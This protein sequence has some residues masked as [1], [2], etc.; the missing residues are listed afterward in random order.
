M[1]KKLHFLLTMMLFCAMLTQAQNVPFHVRFSTSAASC[2]NNGK[3][4]YALMDSQGAVLDSLPD[5]LSQVRI[6][7]RLPNSDT[8]HYSGWY[9]TGGEDTLTINNGTYV[10]G[11]EGLQDNGSGGFVRVDT[12]L[13]MT[14]TTTYQKPEASALVQTAIY[15]TRAGNMPT[16]SCENSGRVQLLVLDGR[17][18]YTVTVCDHSTG[19]TLRTQIFP[20]YQHHGSYAD[21]A[22]Y[23]YYYTFDT[24]GAGTWDFYL[25]DGCGYGLPRI[26]QNVS[27][28][29][30]PKVTKLSV[31]A[32]SGNFA[33]SNVVKVLVKFDKAV[34]PYRT[35]MAQ[36]ARYRIVY[37]GLEAKEWMPLPSSVIENTFMLYDTVYSARKYC[38]IWN[39]KITFE[40]KLEGCEEWQKTLAFQYL[41]PDE[42]YFEKDTADITLAIHENEQPCGTLRDWQRN[43]YS[44]RYYT[45]SV[46]PNKPYL[47]NNIYDVTSDIPIA[48]DYYRYYYTHPLSWVYTDKRTG[49]VIKMDTIGIITDFSYLNAR[50]VE[51][52]YGSLDD[53]TFTIPV[54]RR[55]MDG[56][57]CELYATEDTMTFF[58]SHGRVVP[59][60]TTE[61]TQESQYCC[62][63][64]QS[65]TI[66]QLPSPVSS[67]RISTT[68]RLVRSPDH[69]FYNFVA[70]YDPATERWEITRD[71]VENGAIIEGKYDGRSLSIRDYCL[72][73]GP[74][75][76]EVVTPC[77][78]FLLKLE[79]KFNNYV[80][81]D[82]LEEPTYIVTKDCGNMYIQYTAGRYLRTFFR[83]Y[84]SEDRVDTMES[85]INPIIKVI[86]APHNSY[87]NTSSFSLN[88]PVR[89]SMPGEYIFEFK[90]D[91]INSIPACESMVTYDT[92]EVDI[93][94][95]EFEYALALLCDSSSTMGNAYV[96]G[97]NGTEPYTYILY[98][99]PDRQGEVLGTNNTGVFLNVPMRSNEELSCLISDSCISYFHV[100]FYP[101]TL[102]ELKKVWFDDGLTANST[103]EG[104]TIQVHALSISEVLRYEWS[105]PDGFHAT[106]SDP[107]VHIPRGG[108]SGWYKVVIAYDQCAQELSDSIFLTVQEA[109]HLT[110]T[111]DATVCPGD[112]VEVL[113]VPTTPLD[114]DKVRFEVAF[115]NGSGISSRSYTATPG[116]TVRD[117]FS[118]LSDAKIY[119]VLVDDGRCAYMHADTADTAY[120]HIRT[121]VLPACTVLTTY[122]TVCHG[123]DAQLSA[124]AT[125]SEPY[126]LKWYSDYALTQLLKTDTMINDETWSYYDTAA[127]T[128]R[129]ILYVALETESQCP[130]INGLVSREMDMQDGM[131]VLECGQGVRLFD[132]GGSEE[133][134]PALSSAVH[135]FRSADGRPIVLHFEE[136]ALSK[137]SHLQI[138]TGEELHADSLLWDL[139]SSS[140]NPG[141]VI[142]SGNTLT[143]SFSSGKI[144]A[145][146]WS[147]VVECAPGVAIADVWPKHETV[148]RDEVCQS[149]TRT[150]DDPYGIVPEIAS[151]EELNAAVREAGIY[152]FTKN[153][154][155]M[156]EHGCDSAVT[157]E[158]FVNAPIVH[159]TTV[160]TTVLHGGTFLWHDS[161]YEQSGQ[162]VVQYS[163]TDGCDS[164]EVLSL[165]ILDAHIESENVCRGDSATM[166]VDVSGSAK[167]S[168]VVSVARTGKVGDVLCTDGS[169][170]PVDSFLISNKIAKGV[171]FE[172]DML[173]LHGLAVAL[174]ESTQPMAVTMRGTSILPKSSRESAL[175]DMDGLTN[176]RRIRNAVDAAPNANFEHHAPAAKFC[177]YYDSNT[178]QVGSAL[179]GWY[180][181][182]L[183][184]M[185]VLYI[186]RLKVNR[187]LRKLAE[188]NSNVMP[189]SSSGYWTSTVYNSSKA[190]IISNHG[191]IASSAIENQYG[192]RPIIAF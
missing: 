51:A 18:P 102:A 82:V 84:A 72:L 28:T 29:G 130:T 61:Q 71:R 85:V 100:N 63:D 141:M 155:G 69:N 192:T 68:I 169:L 139:T 147:A 122:D 2:Y 116:D 94:T 179:E 176:T 120:I 132:A 108:S 56:K 106:T 109:P 33:D 10:V 59:A 41:K 96:K 175:W 125:L 22:S 46:Y 78:S 178:F 101:R 118:T 42:R 124:K 9:Y 67:P 52:R 38:D 70:M 37:E 112:S 166:T 157:F 49:E 150:Y 88:T 15:T 53:T 131:T 99:R 43:Y 158:L 138:F 152:Y 16:V 58:R 8:I 60:W 86:K 26:T 25:V 81:M 21:D 45:T 142:S 4:I 74:Y 12:Q 11:V 55:L 149:Q 137:T 177:L 180:M 154:P 148:L 27:V 164:L 136:L 156:G 20:D 95:V 114:V 92:L 79:A 187:T 91:D 87:V 115:S 145:A 174:S 83:R 163:R 77:D 153:Y 34:E 1:K 89:V 127:I 97:K 160:L 50:D 121:D 65:V 182:S 104:T 172:T 36:Y 143:L 80:K 57:G 189:M 165:T 126:L 14:V 133:N 119:S 73:T 135:R 151:S 13:V 188:Q 44:I 173:G 168:R 90:P 103:C 111:P 129:T 98:S 17:F 47:P 167:R 134:Y 62:R 66:L 23:K 75:W 105:G 93:K 117:L 5:G 170:L 76:F 19:D 7:Y 162:Y 191:G 184:E 140:W 186:N 183:G 35:Y 40:Y 107:Y 171:V 113:F 144:S 24:L 123:S 190:W 64:M 159:D 39:R 185:N 32:S 6:Y 128:Q 48:K 3:I 146:G 54:L 181:P 30:L 31:Y 110:V 161:L